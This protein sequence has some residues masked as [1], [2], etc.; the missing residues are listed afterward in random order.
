MT[1]RQ[2]AEQLLIAMAH[3]DVESVAGRVQ[4]PAVSRAKI[5]LATAQ[6]FH[7][8]LRTRLNED[9]TWA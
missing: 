8:E 6:A 7:D 9:H 1:K 3:R 5:A 4:L 2:L